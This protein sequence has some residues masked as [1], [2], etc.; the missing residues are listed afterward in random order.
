MTLE[1]Y[2]IQR[3]FL[4]GSIKLAVEQAVEKFQKTTGHCPHSI[5]IEMRD[6]T[7]FVYGQDMIKWRAKRFK[8]GDVR[9]IVEI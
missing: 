5:T 7:G 6:I 3:K 4:E 1:D 8:I 9:A 2:K